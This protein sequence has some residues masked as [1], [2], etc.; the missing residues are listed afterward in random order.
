MQQPPTTGSAG[1]SS[2]AQGSNGQSGGGTTTDLRAD[3][4]HIGEKAKDR[5]HSEVDN[6]KSTAVSQAQSVSSAIE[7][8][9]GNLDENT[10]EWLK[11]ALQQGAQKIQQFADSIEQKDSRQLV[12]DVQDFA[13]NSP[14]TFLAACA[15]AGFAAARIF[16]AGEQGSQGYSS[17]SGSFDQSQSWGSGEVET[18]GQDS[19]RD[20]GQNDTFGQQ[21][22]ESSTG[23]STGSQAF[24]AR[25]ETQSP[26]SSQFEQNRMEDD[27]LIL[28]AGNSSGSSL[29]GG[30]R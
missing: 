28:G 24:I 8:T 11:S 17:Q 23:S 13:R 7:Q 25:P 5:I 26:T 6:R 14:G 15:A 3:A 29:D 9:A 22:D 10:P 12:R 2:A 21:F 18:L 16:K 27:P 30:S 19:G 20:W 4:Q 1:Q